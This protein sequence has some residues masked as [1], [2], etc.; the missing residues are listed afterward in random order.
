MA[1]VYQGVYEA[2]KKLFVT[3]K[4]G[5]IIV[6][7]IAAITAAHDVSDRAARLLG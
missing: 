1:N 5:H 6:D 2:L 4:D 7:D 3:D